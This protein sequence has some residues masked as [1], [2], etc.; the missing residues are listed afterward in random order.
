MTTVKQ[1]GFGQP[2]DEESSTEQ[3]KK[4]MKVIVMEEESERD[5]RERMLRKII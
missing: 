2:K 4:Q 3:E 5:G 1:K